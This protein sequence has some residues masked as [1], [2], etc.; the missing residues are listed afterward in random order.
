M[1]KICYFHECVMYPTF[2]LHPTCSACPAERV[3]LIFVKCLRVQDL[4]FFTIA[5]HVFG[6][7]CVYAAE[8]LV[9][10]ANLMAY[11]TVTLLF[12]HSVCHVSLFWFMAVT[13]IM[14]DISNAAVTVVDVFL[15]W[16]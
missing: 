1:L 2:L 14:A 16:V 10:V 13:T 6:D 3:F 11:D 8:T 12:T 4:N 9:C 7:L 5:S 15:S